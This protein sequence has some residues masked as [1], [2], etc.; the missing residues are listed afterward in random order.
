MSRLSQSTHRFTVAARNTEESVDLSPATR[1]WTAPRNNTALGH[2]SGRNKLR[3]A[4]YFL[5]TYSATRRRG[6]KLS[7]RATDVTRIALVATTGPRHGTVKVYL[8]SMLLRRVVLNSDSLT[9]KRVIS[10]ANFGDMPR[11]G[12]ISVVVT[13]T[14][15]PV[16]IE[17]LAVATG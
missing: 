4:G 1:V 10:I 5:G 12:S 13:S 7:T 3:A 11:T 17:G 2:S 8:G 16:R 9:K 6:A 15:K 14:D